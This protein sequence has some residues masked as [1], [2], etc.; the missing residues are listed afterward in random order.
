[1][2]QKNQV[3]IMKAKSPI[4]ET[5]I[6]LAWLNSSFELSKERIN[7]LTYRSIEIM[8]SDWKK[9]VEKTEQPQKNVGCTCVMKVTNEKSKRSRKNIWSNH[10]WT[11]SKF[12]EN[13]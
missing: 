13:Y 6:L 5:K 9:R 3:I 4:T 1:M 10:G 8:Q 2:I 7:E 11:L 12:D